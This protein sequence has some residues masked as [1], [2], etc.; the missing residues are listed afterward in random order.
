MYKKSKIWS[1]SVLILAMLV[2]VLSA[3]SA[4]AN[5]SDRDRDRERDHNS[6]RPRINS[7]ISTTNNSAS[8]S[9]RAKKFKNETV[10]A[11]VSVKER[12][13]EMIV[14]KAMKVTLDEKGNGTVTVKGL[15]S[16]TRYD[17]K[18]RIMR[19]DSDKSTENS[20]SRS[21]RTM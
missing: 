12:S 18:V 17:F 2:L 8:I 13:T 11:I 6:G 5:S 9:F 15:K 20:K 16:G 14:E 10:N 3:G 19:M 21:G 1:A 4:S 7:D